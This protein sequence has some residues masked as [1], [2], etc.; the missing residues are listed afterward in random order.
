MGGCWNRS[1]IGLYMYVGLGMVWSDKYMTCFR[2]RLD[3]Y[4][5]NYMI[6]LEIFF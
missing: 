6:Q 5:Y 3:Q 1:N 4:F 2:V